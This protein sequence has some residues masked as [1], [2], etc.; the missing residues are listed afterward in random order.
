MGADAAAARLEERRGGGIVFG[1]ERGG[2]AWPAILRRLAGRAR[3][4]AACRSDIRYAAVR[5][6]PRRAAAAGGDD[7]AAADRIYEKAD[8]RFAHGGHP[9]AD[10]GEC[11]ESVAGVSRAGPDA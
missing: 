1:G 2:P 9:R 4:V 3:Q 10:A 7:H 6:A 5:A 11:L 8:R